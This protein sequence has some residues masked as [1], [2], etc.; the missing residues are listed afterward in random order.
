MATYGKTWAFVLAVAALCAAAA[1][2]MISFGDIVQDDAFISYRYAR[3]LAEGHGLVYNPGERVE[4]YSDFLWTVAIAAAVKTG[5]AAEVAGRWLG[6]ACALA[7]VAATA[8]LARRWGGFW[9]GLVAAAMLALNANFLVEGAQGLETALFVLVVTLGAARAA[10]EYVDPTCRPLSALFLILAM[11]TRVDGALVWLVVLPFYLSTARA[12]PKRFVVWAA[13]FLAATAG[14]EVWRLAYYGA[15]FPN[16]FYAKVA[17]GLDPLRTGFPYTGTF[18]LRFTPV[19]LFIPLAARRRREFYVW[20]ALALVFLVYVTAVG[21]DIKSTDR[22]YLPIVPLA[23]IALA[24][25]AADISAAVT[26]APRWTKALV[27]VALVGTHVLGFVPGFQ[28][29][30]DYRYPHDLHV[31]AGKWLA[32][33][34]PPGATLATSA[35]GIIPYYSGLPTIDILGLTDRHVAREGRRTATLPGHGLSDAEYVL[36]RKPTYIL[37]YEAVLEPYVPSEEAVLSAAHWPA[38]RELAASPRFHEE[39]V[40]S[41]AEIMPGEYFLYFIRA[42][43]GT[44]P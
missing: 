38:A 3:N 25:A 10:K 7:A 8:I 33:N 15:P 35:A 4:G 1:A 24:A 44:G 14:F 22:F 42:D 11:L 18:L 43:G 21:G 20:G 36:S 39:Y 13:T 5:V 41:H 19:L 23:L 29:A 30:K 40:F 9:L 16:T 28:F 27:G 32:A 26:W 31:A 12:N 6:M 34:A 2:I 37:I 17:L